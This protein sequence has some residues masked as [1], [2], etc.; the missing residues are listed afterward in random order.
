MK[1]P[2]LRD[3]RG[4]SLIEVLT[5]VAITGVVMVIA[6]PMM[7]NLFGFFRLSGDAR[8]ISNA[9]AVAKM[10]AAS[11]FSRVRIYV[12]LS[13]RT[14]NQNGHSL[15]AMITTSGSWPL[16][17]AFDW[18]SAGLSTASI[19]RLKLFTLDNR[20]LIRILGKLKE[21][22]LET[23]ERNFHRTLS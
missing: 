19:I 20:L 8:S 17:I 14:F 10:R 15:I 4:Y 23:V 1:H 18:A 7:G 2:L 5:V 3:R 16:D 13:G 6:V 22:D 9:I 11:D 12:D 21:H